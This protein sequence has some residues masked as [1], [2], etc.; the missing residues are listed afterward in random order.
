MIFF[1]RAA[2]ALLLAA[3][4]GAAASASC[5]L[6]SAPSSRWTIVRERG[7]AWL[8]DPCGQRLV[9]LGV[10]I[11]DGGASGDNVDH[12]HY[13]WRRFAP[14]RADWVAATRQRLDAWGFNSAG[15][16][17]LPPQVLRMPTAI[18]LELGRFAR[19]HWFDPFD[20]A[21]TR[22]MYAEARRL[23]APYR[24]TPYRIG[25]FSDNEVGWWS[26]ALTQF[27][28]QKP[29][30]NHTKRRWVALMRRLYRGDWGRFAADFVPPAG[31]SS[32]HGLLAATAPTRLRPGGD[33]V[34]AVRA[35]TATVARRYYEVAAAA[36]HQAD[37]E[38]LY[39]G[40]R[41]PIY[42]DPDAIRAEAPHVDAIAVNYNVDSPEGWIA[43]YF[44][45]GLRRLSGAKPVLVS[46]WFYA[47]RE[48]RSGNTNNG[49]LMT[50]DT[51][52]ER[53]AG[54]AAAEA[55]F[56]QVPEL[57]GLHWFQYYD[58]PSGGR[59][60]GEDYDFGLVDIDDRPYGSL[61]TALTA[62]NH[63]LPRLHATARPLPRSGAIALP[64]AQIDLE[65]RSLVDWPKPASLLPPLKTAPGEVAFGEVYL[66]WSRA[67]L[68]LAHIGQDYYDPDLL[69]YD[70]PY[71]GR[72]AYQVD[73]G[74]DTGA[75]AK[76]F[77]LYLMPPPRGAPEHTMHAVLCQGID[78]AT[79]RP[80]EGGSTLYYGADQP[81]VVEAALVPWSAMGGKPASG[82]LKFEVAVRSWY[83]AR[84][85]SLSGKEPAAALADATKWATLPLGD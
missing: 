33:G 61:V 3:L 35:W 81:R 25:Y 7:V 47:A 39:F 36:I 10:D 54:A 2:G 22:R 15:A 20:P 8:K 67:G 21:T 83:R 37:P 77:T 59:A 60:D 75:G 57:M 55:N 84:W 71:P 38:A 32:W 70:G 68:A 41:L 16:W 74:V 51:Q 11:V 42:Y 30:S 46:E 17:S 34:R 26:G 49:H 18:N 76:R 73:F 29:A 52:S 13:D 72:Q 9:S 12:P 23:T 50:V 31:V 1:H 44:F 79:C 43:P 19:F 24:G 4:W 6:G 62:A 78:E 69:A 65:Q 27:F 48:N 66:S 40:D 28:S 85:M 53:A 63:A 82:K 58:Y 45:D 80:V 64:E 14:T 5:Q 56:A